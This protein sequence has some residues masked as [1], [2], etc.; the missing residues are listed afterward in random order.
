MFG[1]RV[2]VPWHRE[3]DA[4]HVLDGLALDEDQPE[5]EAP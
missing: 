5:E 4:R 3:D 2:M 1:V